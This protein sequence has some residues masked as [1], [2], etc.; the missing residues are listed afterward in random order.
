MSNRFTLLL[1]AAAVATACG[2]PAPQNS[3]GEAGS[4]TDGASSD[5]LDDRPVLVEVESKEDRQ[6]PTTGRSER[7]SD[8][9]L[10]KSPVPAM[11][12]VIATGAVRRAKIAGDVAALKSM[13]QTMAQSMP[14][15][16]G[17]P[18]PVDPYPPHYQDQGRENYEAFDDNGLFWAHQTP[19][20]TFSID[21]DTASYANVRRFLN[22]GHLPN[23]EAV[24]VE[25]LVN[26]F[27]YTYPTNRDERA[28]REQP[29][30]VYTE[31]GPSPW[32]ADQK[33]VHIGVNGWQ[34]DAAELPPANLVFLIDVSG[35]MNAPNKLG[36]LRQAMKMLARQLRPEDRL[37]I[38]VYAG[39]SGTV[40]EPT[41]GGD[42][43]K[44]AQAIDNLQAGGSTNG[45][46]GIRLAYNLAKQN[47]IKEGVNRVILATDGDFNVGTTDI[48]ELERMVERERA[49]GVALSV[50]GFGT[51]NYND[52]LMQK[53][54]Q[55]GNGNAA[56]IDTMNEARK[57]L[58]DELAA[59]L[60]IIAQDVKIQVEFNPEVVATYRLIGYETRHLNREDFNNDKIDAGEIGAGHRVTALYEI[61]LTNAEQTLIDPLRYG[62]QQSEPVVKGDFGPNDEI[63]F[64]KLRYKAPGGD[65]SKLITQPLFVRDMQT[66]ID[67]T[68]ETYRFAA[69][70]AWFGQ[71][72]RENKLVH[73]DDMN[74][75]ID[76]A[77]TAKGTD[78]HG[79]RAE[80]IG[81]ARTAGALATPAGEAAGG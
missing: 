43:A 47:F 21:V 29:F 62:E 81:L 53:I 26:Y 46:A 14:H 4:T 55:I 67:A 49:S 54:A 18:H 57:V 34:E 24:R 19:V 76:L 30:S 65:R 31:I 66:N 27:D 48:G 44:I 45:G 39:S 7:D 77:N 51:G 8:D 22:E 3:P 6:Q 37:S 13:P 35:S 1:L 28:S 80:F 12:E 68:S 41:A 9:A 75:V 52:H 36:L 40:L 69:A 10:V 74:G 79:Y 42:Y 60:N 23:P 71:I 61:G 73:G 2:S 70:V 33:L 32:S 11:E 58:V 38:A 5:R 20:S 16:P 50:L 15:H 56:Y 59:T 72:L 78:G 63:A 17:L 64:V 25:E